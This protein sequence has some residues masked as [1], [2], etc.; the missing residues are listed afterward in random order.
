MLRRAFLLFIALVLQAAQAQQVE[1]HGVPAS[2]LSPTSPGVGHGVPSS[3]TSPAPRIGPNGRIFINPRHF[4]A[5]FGDSRV[6][7][8][9]RDF[10]P[11][12]IFIPTYPINADYSYAEPESAPPDESATED[13]PPVSSSSADAESLREAY[14]RGARDALAQQAENRYGEHYLDGREK[15]RN[16][17]PASKEQAAPKPG[18]KEATSETE[19]T[20]KEEPADNSPA[21]VFIFKD[22]HKL[23]TQNY[24]IVGQTLFD[25]S[26]NQV[27][28]IKLDELD[29]D[30]TKRANDDLGIT[31]RFS[32][33]P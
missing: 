25:F 28:K 30:A 1:S 3:I 32:P 21:T 19:N 10:V 22:G 26:K 33:T 7:H 18:A 12:P 29:L 6:R 16:K 4:R 14:Y 23:E 5:R 15:A 20:A 31:L 17:P 9:R 24:A 8:G 13:A 11:V 2:I 27:R